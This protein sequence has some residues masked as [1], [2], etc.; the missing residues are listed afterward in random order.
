MQNPKIYS[1]K[2]YIYNLLFYNLFNI[3]NIYIKKKK[4]HLYIYIYKIK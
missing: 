1:L 4:I 2:K 3:I